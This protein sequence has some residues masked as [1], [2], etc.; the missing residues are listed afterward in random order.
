MTLRNIPGFLGLTRAET[1]TRQAA[2]DRRQ[3]ELLLDVFEAVQVAAV[4]R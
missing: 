1:G 4:S 2:S 3:Q